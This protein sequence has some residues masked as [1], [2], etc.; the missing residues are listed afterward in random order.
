MY[1]ISVFTLGTTLAPLP[2]SRSC[3]SSTYAHARTHTYANTRAHAS[4]HVSF[5]VFQSLHP[6]PLSSSFST[7]LQLAAPRLHVFSLV[8]H[9]R[10]L[11]FILALM[12]PNVFARITNYSVSRPCPCLLSSL[13]PCNHCRMKH[14][15]RA[16]APRPRV[17]PSLSR[18]SRPIRE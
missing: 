16:H 6:L 11:A 7:L 1:R 15:A 9:T 14:N 10:L 3:C 5:S 18:S 4:A 13:L 2:P 12:Q 17:R 8:T